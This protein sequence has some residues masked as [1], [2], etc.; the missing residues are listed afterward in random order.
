MLGLADAPVEL[1]VASV[2]HVANLVHLAQILIKFEGQRLG[3][4]LDA[5]HKAR[6]TRKIEQ[7]VS[8]GTSVSMGITSYPLDLNGLGEIAGEQ[9][10]GE[11]LSW[12]GGGQLERRKLL[13]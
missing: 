3:K 9:V 6:T 8:S 1:K 5:D 11:G 10:G 12:R 7:I 4:E 2:G 13:R